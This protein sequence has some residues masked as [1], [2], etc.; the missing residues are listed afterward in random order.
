MYVQCER[1]KTEYDFDDA[2]VSERGTTVKCTSCG[3]QFKVFRTAAGG[4]EDRWQVTTGTGKE[5]VFLSLKELQRAILAKLVGRS[6]TLARGGATPRALGSIAELEPFFDDKRRSPSQPEGKSS[7]PPPPPGTASPALSAPTRGKRVDTLRPPAGPPPAQD[8]KPMRSS[9][10]RTYVGVAP[11]ANLPPALKATQVGLPPSPDHRND[12]DGHGHDQPADPPPAPRTAP[13]IDA[14]PRPPPMIA[15]LGQVLAPAL[16]A[17]PPP[18]RPP[19][20]VNPPVMRPPPPHTPPTPY[21]Q[22]QQMPQMIDASSPLPPPTVPRRSPQYDEGPVAARALMDGRPSLPPP[23]RRMGGWIVAAALLLGVGALSMYVARPYL[24]HLGSSQQKP[25]PL[26]PKVAQF[27][28]AGEAAL[29]EGNL[30]G[31]KENF[32]K[33][34]ALAESDPKVL[35]DEAR[36][37]S[38]RAD[39]PWLKQRLLAVDAPDLKANRASLDELAARARHSSEM[40]L[41]ASPDDGAAVRVRVDALRIAGDRDAARA[42]VGKVAANPSLPEAAYVL[43]ALDMAELDP[44][45]PMIIDRLR[46]AASAEAGLGRARAALVY[47]LAKSGDVAGAKVELDRLSNL[48]RQH[49]LLPLLKPFVDKSPAKTDSGVVD[50]S[51]LPVQGGATASPSSVGAT[52]GAAGTVPTPPGAGSATAPAGG[53]GGGGVPSDP[54]VALQQ[55]DSARNRHDYARARLLYQAVLAKSPSDSEALAGLGDVSH[56]QHDLQGAASFYRQA[57]SA[58][59]SFLPALLGLANVQWE[60]GDKGAAQKTYRDIIDRFPEASYP[61]YVKQRANESSGGGAGGGGAPSGTESTGSK[62]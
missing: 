29:G 44:A 19:P 48:P 13:M 45:W 53:G 36:L 61:S 8:S 59:P 35:I 54:R 21:A 9:S 34:S 38:V 33:A 57:L 6:D 40:A 50:P 39:V 46:N 11:Q 58:N 4:D 31:A 1:C 32:D 15:E 47:A 24:E 55:A 3:N 2:L 23:R 20:P 30:D 17:P 37:D 10:V 52:A 43:A 22:G 49:P 18:R 60:S 51:K 41:T 5:L 62:E 28:G 14:S 12:G 26:S 27:L 7:R 16:V 56:E 42:L 25:T